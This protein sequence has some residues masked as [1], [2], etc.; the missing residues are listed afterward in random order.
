MFMRIWNYK[1][2]NLAPVD[3]HVNTSIQIHCAQGGVVQEHV[4]RELSLLP[5][6]T[7]DKPSPNIL[8]EPTVIEITCVRL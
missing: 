1:T 8:S 5:P 7:V 6:C 3:Q 2:G 4:L